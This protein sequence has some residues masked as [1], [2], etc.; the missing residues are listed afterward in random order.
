M[1][2][3]IGDFQRYWKNSWQRNFRTPTAV[4]NNA[5]LDWTKRYS[6]FKKG[7]I[8]GVWN[9][10]SD[11]ATARAF[12]IAWSPKGDGVEVL[13]KASAC[14]LRW[15]GSD[16]QPDSPGFFVLPIQVFGRPDVIP[17]G[18]QIMKKEYITQV[19]S[20]GMQKVIASHY[21]EAAAHASIAWLKECATHGTI[22][23]TYKNPAETEDTTVVDKSK[24]GSD[25]LVGVE[26]REGDFVLM[27][28]DYE[29]NPL[30]DLSGEEFWRLP[31]EIQSQID[32]DIRQALAARRSQ[33]GTPNVRYTRVTKS[34][35]REVQQAAD[36]K[37]Q[38][39]E[40]V[41]RH[42][43]LVRVR[44][45]LPGSAAN[46]NGQHAAADGAD[47]TSTSDRL[48]ESSSQ[49]PSSSK[50]RR[51][52][53]GCFQE[54]VESEEDESPEVAVQLDF[55]AISE[56]GEGDDSLAR[57]PEK[58]WGAPFS[59]CKLGGY[60]IVHTEFDDVDGGVGVEL[61]KVK[62]KTEGCNNEADSFKGVKY[63]PSKVGVMVTSEECLDCKWHAASAPQEKVVC[64][65]VLHYF[66]KLLGSKKIPVPDKKALRAK[67]LEHNIVLFEAPVTR[68][69][70]NI[71]DLN[72]DAPPSAGE[73]EEEEEEEE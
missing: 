56:D 9:T 47:T 4:L 34:Y 31:D 36:K 33:A 64:W 52:D 63:I 3:T 2:A 60:A 57:L 59:S 58:Q 17:A 50:R 35:A 14:D 20:R 8:S 23:F 48:T 6:P 61:Y 15:L 49:E 30:A 1:S 44:S 32:D 28:D 42:K 24:W 22:P 73:E 45:S 65:Q 12:K 29:K 25:V 51:L 11:P 7:R 37:T 55:D 69:I 72:L 70:E 18:K 19:T 54:G 21:G 26:N 5:H 39:A 40:R 67:A 27:R 13:F 43:M 68:E 62:S 38:R 46:S 41:E 53:A 71:F 10:P 16:H 66:A